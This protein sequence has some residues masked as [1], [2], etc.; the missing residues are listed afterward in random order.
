MIKTDDCVAMPELSRQFYN[1]SAYR[2][3]KRIIEKDGFNKAYAV[4]AVWNGRKKKWEVFDGIHRLKVAQDL[5]IK[6]IP[7]IDETDFYNRR[8]AIAEG[9][10]AN[11]TH[12]SYNPIDLARHLRVLGEHL[13][14]ISKKRQKTGRPATIARRQLSEHT[15]MDESLIKHYISLLRLPR[16]VQDMIGQGK[17]STSKAVE[18]VSLVDTPYEDQIPTL[19]EKIVKEGWTRDR[20]RAVVHS[21]KR[22][23]NYPSF[24]SKPC[25]ICGKVPP[26]DILTNISACPP[27]AT[28]VRN[29]K[30]KAIKD[31]RDE[32]LQKWLRW[33]NHLENLQRDHVEIDPHLKGYVQK[34]HDDYFFGEI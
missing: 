16:D 25:E 15:G 17:L 33:S 27:C 24:T 21:I 32:L 8:Q 5:E 6:K 28:N 23:G 7:L 31:E 3:L 26:Q 12:A 22:K 19:A 13:A 1:D 34:L 11:K 10:K 30:V 20:V 9:I 29:S 18:L 14:K 4:R 2:Y